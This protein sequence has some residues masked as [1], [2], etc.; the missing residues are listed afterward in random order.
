M[1]QKHL[2]YLRKADCW[3]HNSIKCS[4]IHQTSTIHFVRLLVVHMKEFA[5]L[6]HSISMVISY[7]T[8]KCSGVFH[9]RKII[10]FPYFNN[11]LQL[12]TFVRDS[13]NHHFKQEQIAMPNVLFCSSLLL[14]T[15]KRSGAYFNDV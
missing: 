6:C 15:V 10:S 4:S 5:A 12:R 7:K 2:I 13:G 8:R 1:F 11:R 3:Y 14:G 9:L